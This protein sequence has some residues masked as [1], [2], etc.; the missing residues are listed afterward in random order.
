MKHPLP[1]DTNAPTETLPDLSIEELM[2]LLRIYKETAE[3]NLRQ[4]AGEPAAELMLKITGNAILYLSAYKNGLD[5]LQKFNEKMNYIR[6]RC[7][8]LDEPRQ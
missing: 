6:L 2:S 7:A 1:T 3:K 8:P 5:A 4:N